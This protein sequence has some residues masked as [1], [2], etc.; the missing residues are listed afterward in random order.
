MPNTT[1]NFMILIKAM[2]AILEACPC[3]KGNG[4]KGAV[5]RNWENWRKGRLWL[6]CLE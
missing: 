3:L 6:G 2:V 5:V 4:G 1:A